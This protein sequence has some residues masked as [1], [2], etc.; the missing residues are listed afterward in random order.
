MTDF[1]RL[2]EGLQ[3]RRPEALKELMSRFGAMVFRHAR[4]TLGN[5]QDAEDM[6]QEVFLR[7][8]RFS[9][10]FQGKSIA[11]WL[12][13]ITHHCCLDWLQK[14]RRQD[15]IVTELEGQSR[16]GM[17]SRPDPDLEEFLAPLSPRDRSVMV[18][19]FADDLS[20]GEIAE[21][22]GL[23]EGTLRNIVSQN[24]KLIRENQTHE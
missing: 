11:R 18:L 5:D 6:Y 16:C 13:R 9:A 17:L 22:T 12:F 8:F 15:D 20:Y 3:Q 2:I 14:V 1:D 23:T 7:A 4:L 19:R 24:L 10:S 21:I